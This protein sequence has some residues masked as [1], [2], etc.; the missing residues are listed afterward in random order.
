MC[1][2]GVPL[3][4]KGRG[5]EGRL[6]KAQA[7]THTHTHT[8]THIHT[9]THTHA[10]LEELFLELPKSLVD[11][12]LEGCHINHIEYSR[13][14]RPRRELGGDGGAGQTCRAMI[15]TFQL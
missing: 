2:R 9:H 3:L 15:L 10:H 6:V 13:D 8:Y 4:G 5:K 7:G 14:Y 1:I 12:R 11:K